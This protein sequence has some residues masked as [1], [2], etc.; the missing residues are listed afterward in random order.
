VATILLLSF[1][2]HVPLLWYLIPA[3]II[4]GLLLSSRLR[5]N[6]HNPLQVWFGLLT[7]FLGLLFMMILFQ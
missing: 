4:A 2:T 3:V 6:F 5:L 7:G 1:K